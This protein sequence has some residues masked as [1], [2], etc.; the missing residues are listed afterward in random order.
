MELGLLA[1]HLVLRRRLRARKRW[2][3]DRLRGQ[4]RMRSPSCAPTRWPRSPFS[5]AL[6]CRTLG[7]TA[8]RAAGPDQ[9]R[10]HGELRRSRHQ[11][12][13]RDGGTFPFIRTCFTMCSIGSA[14]ANGRS[15]RMGRR[16][17]FWS[18]G[19]APTSTESRCS[20]R[21]AGLSARAVPRRP[22]CAGPGS[23]RSPGPARGRRPSSAPPLSPTD[24]ESTE[25]K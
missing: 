18:R 1:R 9:G 13:S 6:P 12:P 5:P 10:A 11:L 2:S 25:P 3:P 15:Y 16:S 22:R 19:R 17:S 24:A 21:S 14:P 4:K 7:P 8:R 20:P 23:T